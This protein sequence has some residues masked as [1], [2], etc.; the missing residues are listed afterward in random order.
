MSHDPP[1]APGYIMLNHWSNGD[2]SWSGGP[3]TSDAVMTVSYVK[4][5]FNTTDSHRTSQHKKQCGTFKP[6]QV[7]QIPEQT[8]APDLAGANGN[9]TART[10]FFSKDPGH[11][12]GQVLYNVDNAGSFSAVSPLLVGLA[13]FAEWL[14]V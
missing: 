6:S 8:T 5:Y 4:A 2:P 14:V 10:Y 13:L 11:T 9:A 7:C 1:D 12:P 3:P